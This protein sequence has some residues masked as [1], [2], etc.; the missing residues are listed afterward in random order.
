MW[1]TCATSAAAAAR[2]YGGLARGGRL[3]PGDMLPSRAAYPSPR[4]SLNSS[5]SYLRD[6]IHRALSV[7]QEAHRRVRRDA[8]GT[9]GV[10]RCAAVTCRELCQSCS[11]RVSFPSAISARRRSVHCLSLSVDELR[12]HR[13]GRAEQ[14]QHHC[15]TLAGECGQGG[16][17]RA[18]TENQPTRKDHPPTKIQPSCR[19]L[20]H[21]K[22]AQGRTLDVLEV[23]IPHS[24]RGGGELRTGMACPPC[25]D[26]PPYQVPRTVAGARAGFWGCGGVPSPA[27]NQLK[28]SK[29]GLDFVECTPLLV[30]PDFQAVV[31]GVVPGP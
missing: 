26:V 6:L 10:Q 2:A 4:C 18:E 12:T 14:Q 7:A 22:S 24:G 23:A 30:A 5:S 31:E 19:R 28:R 27:A 17:A 21:K 3:T 1:C 16:A 29:R 9:G 11:R 20:Q 8:T 15:A 25:G 13:S